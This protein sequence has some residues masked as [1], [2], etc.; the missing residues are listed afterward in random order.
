LA[1]IGSIFEVMGLFDRIGNG[2]VRV[3]E[4]VEEGSKH[5]VVGVVM[6]GGAALIGE[7]IAQPISAGMSLIGK[8][9]EADRHYQEKMY[10]PI[11]KDV[12]GN[13]GNFAKDTVSLVT[14]MTSNVLHVPGAVLDVARGVNN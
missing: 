8:G 6:G 9:D 7:A 11:V 5:G 4:A 12:K 14:G 1:F 10:N 3:F 2:I 13:N